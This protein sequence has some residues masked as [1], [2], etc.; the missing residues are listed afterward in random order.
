MRTRTSLFAAGVIGLAVVVAVVFEGRPQSSTKPEVAGIGITMSPQAAFSATIATAVGGVPDQSDQFAMLGSLDGREDNLADHTFLVANPGGT[1]T[2]PAAFV[3]REAISEHTIANGFAENIFYYGDSAGNVVVGSGDTTNGGLIN[4]S[5]TINLP[6]AL[7]AFGTLNSNSQIVITGLA[8]SPVADLTSFANVNGSYAGF[9]GQIGEILYVTYTDT[10]GGMRLFSN[11]QI[12]QSGLLAYPVADVTSPAPNPPGIV[13]STGFPVT[14]G[15][16]FGVAFSTFSNQAGVAVDDDAN[17]YFQQVDLIGKTGGN[18]VKVTIS[19]SDRDR[20]TA[21]DGFLTTNTLNPTGGNYGTASGPSSQVNTFTNYTGTA[22]LFGNIAA[23]ATG[24]SNVLYAAVSQSF[25]PKDTAAVQATEGPFQNLSKLGPTPSMII[26]FA[27]AVG[28]TNPCFA[29]LPAPDGFADPIN[30]AKLNPGVNNFRVFVLGNGPDLRGKFDAFGGKTSTQ[31]ISFQVDY[32]IYSGLTVDEEGKVYLIS[33]GTPAGVGNNPSPG[34]GEILAFPDD[35][36]YDRR[37]DYID[38]RG[39]VVPNPSVTNQNKG[40]GRSDRF[41]HI[42]WTAPLDANNNPVGIAGLTH[43][44][45]LY[46]SRTRPT[47][48]T[49]LDLLPNGATQDEDTTTG[50][51]FF[52]DFDLSHQVAGG[53]DQNFPFRGDDSDGFSAPSDP[54]V[55]EPLGGGF[56]YNFAADVAGVCTT[57]WNTFFLNSNG[58]VTF[59]SGDT[60]GTSA[61]DSFLEG[62]P[63]IAGA[64]VNLNPES[65]A[66]G[67]MN[68]FPIQ[69]IGFANIN[70]FKVRYID[71]PE[72]GEETCGSSNSFDIFLYDD[73]TGVDENA[74]QTLNSANPIGNNVVP[75]DLQ[76]GP[77]DLRFNRAGVGAPPRPD[78]SG[79]SRLHYGRMDLIGSSNDPV[80]VGYSIGGQSASPPGL[81]SKNN[82][83]K[84]PIGKLI[85]NGTQGAVFQFFDTGTDAAP[86]FD[87]R[88]EGANRKLAS[89]IKKTKD[90]SRDTLLTNPLTDCSVTPTFTCPK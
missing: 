57:P 22:P 66:E 41:D 49:S 69:A 53:D 78:L 12:V 26:S 16:A 31:Q 59:G 73:G 44:F 6:T 64:W 38:L 14:M 29:A 68:T 48:G 25:N 9:S 10:G 7:N 71:V 46:T 2:N 3:T 43:G 37:A 1:F 13:S 24:P 90:E 20:S 75:F 19:G 27:D 47:T 42:Y 51:L 39:E 23:I 56:E 63:R 80:L 60:T 88:F 58:N 4:N 85:G 79:W 5:F 82:F 50:P 11:G 21:T 72:S 77:T 17:V 8:V 52:E 87:L 81:C 65:R 45:L 36:P 83:S 76:E 28:G 40:N 34:L 15:N 35:S 30:T 74:T 86:V 61:I 67:N 54:P 32:T 89:V 84:F 55:T 70:D 18:I 62:A 33:G